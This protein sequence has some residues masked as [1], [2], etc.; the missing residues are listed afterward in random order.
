[1]GG[2]KMNI[3]KII[4][5]L[6]EHEKQLSKIRKTPSEDNESLMHDI[7]YKITSIILD[8]YDEAERKK[9]FQGI[10]CPLYIA[11]SEKFAFYERDIESC[12]SGISVVKQD[13]ELE[14]FDNKQ[15]VNLPNQLPASNIIN[16][17]NTNQLNV[18]INSFTEIYQKLER[19]EFPNKEEIKK[20]L[21]EIE[22]ESK[23]EFIERPHLR[24][25]FSKL[26]SIGKDFLKQV[27]LSVIVNL[28]TQG[29][30]EGL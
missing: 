22:I 24:K 29:L 25:L 20:I 16:I 28:F 6:D 10:F 5:K 21:E 13:F 23:K 2:Y 3:K 30:L 9:L 7:R 4:S 26:Q 17:N 11:P 18:N 27:P 8:L 1:M 15:K 14:K 12:L 19:Q